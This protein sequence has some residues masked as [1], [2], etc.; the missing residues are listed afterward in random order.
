MPPQNP[1]LV[2]LDAVLTKHLEPLVARIQRIQE[3]IDRLD[4]TVHSGDEGQGLRSLT[5]RVRGLEERL[6]GLEER[7]RRKRAWVAGFAVSLGVIV[8]LGGLLLNSV[9][10]QLKTIITLM[11]GT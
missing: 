2:D 5:A 9:M 7:E 11:G 10:G 4:V 8:G 6:T 3:A 1:Q